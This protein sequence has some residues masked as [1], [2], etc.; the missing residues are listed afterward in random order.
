MPFRPPRWLTGWL[1]KTRFKMTSKQAEYLSIITNYNIESEPY[2]E[3]CFGYLFDYGIRSKK[4]IINILE[5][6]KDRLKDV[7]IFWG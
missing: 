1:I 5:K 4:P 2:G 6:Y 7:C 3:R